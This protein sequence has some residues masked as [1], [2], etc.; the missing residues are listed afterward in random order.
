MILAFTGANG[1][2]S[3]PVAVV[4]TAALASAFFVIAILFVV[5]RGFDTLH[6]NQEE[7]I[8]LKNNEIELQ[9]EQLKMLK[10]IARQGESIQK[11][12]PVKEPD[13]FPNF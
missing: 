6:F 8:R 1:T 4:A 3:S 13:E 9:K 5:A 11:P 2:R 12:L 10:Y 7:Q